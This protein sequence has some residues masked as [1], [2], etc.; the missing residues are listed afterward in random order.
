MRDGIEALSDWF[1]PRE[2]RVNDLSTE[3]LDELIDLAGLHLSHSESNG[4]RSRV[5]KWLN[6]ASGHNFPLDCKS[7]RLVVRERAGGSKPALYQIQ[8][9]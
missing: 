6:R 2:F 1:G 7:V 8:T 5:G 3:R 9:G 4:R